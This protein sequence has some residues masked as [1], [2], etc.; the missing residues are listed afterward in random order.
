MYALGSELG[1]SMQQVNGRNI[2]ETKLFTVGTKAAQNTF[3]SLLL[4]VITEH[5]LEVILEA[6]LKI[7]KEDLRNEAAGLAANDENNGGLGTYLWAFVIL[8]EQEKAEEVS[9]TA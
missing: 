8:A 6:L 9:Q 2:P 7:A 5:E 3:K 1:R 4:G